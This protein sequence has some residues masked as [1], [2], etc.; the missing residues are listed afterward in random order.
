MKAVKGTPFEHP[1]MSGLALVD[2]RY[3]IG[4]KCKTCGN[5]IRTAKRGVCIKCSRKYSEEYRRL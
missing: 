1:I 3:T 2:N 5:S 4:K